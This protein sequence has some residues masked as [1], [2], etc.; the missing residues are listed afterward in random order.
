M[1]LIETIHPSNIIDNVNGLGAVPNN[2][3]VDYFGFSVQMKPSV[4]RKLA[5]PL[6][7]DRATSVEGLVEQLKAGRKM[8]APFLIM[9]FDPDEPTIPARV[10]SHEGRNRMYAVEEL[11]GDVPIEVH[12]FFQHEVRRRH[13]TDEHI[14][15]MRNRLIPEK[16][17]RPV[18]GPFW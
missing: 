8:G 15:F 17:E 6:E 9:S 16:Q 1:L 7:R 4:F 5:A 18:Q 10:M 13:L 12:L 14:E 11:F 2:Q 3:S